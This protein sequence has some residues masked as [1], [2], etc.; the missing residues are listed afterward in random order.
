MSVS[1]RSPSKPI[2]FKAIF[3]L[4]KKNF[5]PLF[6]ALNSWPSAERRPGEPRRRNF[7]SGKYQHTVQLPEEAGLQP[8]LLRANRELSA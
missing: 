1:V 8:E 6:A 7:E 3:F 5:L 4:I 2:K